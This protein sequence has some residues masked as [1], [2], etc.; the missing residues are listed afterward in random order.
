MI[1][2]KTRKREVEYITSK[3]RKREVEYITTKTRKRGAFPGFVLSPKQEP[4]DDVWEQTSLLPKRH[5]MALALA[6]YHRNF[7][8][9][10]YY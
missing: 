5:L 4:S 3:T 9:I 6:C 7:I 2:T 8:K 10:L 1:T